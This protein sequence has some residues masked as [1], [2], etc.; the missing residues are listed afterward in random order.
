MT[1]K[2]Q[3]IILTLSDGREIIATTKEFMKEDEKLKLERI[4]ITAPRELPDG[5]IF[6][7]YDV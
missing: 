3:N 5:I 4:Q 7:E 1:E 2:F 6:E